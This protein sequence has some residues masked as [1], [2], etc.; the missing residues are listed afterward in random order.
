MVASMQVN[1]GLLT[2]YA[3]SAAGVPQLGSRPRGQGSGAAEAFN[4]CE[5]SAVREDHR[6][7]SKDARA[8]VTRQVQVRAD[9]ALAF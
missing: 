9:F 8:P 7:R 4:G 6:R 1:N 2:R 5:K 3:E